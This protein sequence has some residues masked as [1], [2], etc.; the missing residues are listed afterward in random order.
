[1]LSLKVVML[2]VF[3][4]ALLLPLM[5]FQAVRGM[6]GV[7]ATVSVAIP[8]DPTVIAGAAVAAVAATTNAVAAAAGGGDMERSGSLL[9]L[10]C[11]PRPPRGTEPGEDDVDDETA[12]P[13]CQPPSDDDRL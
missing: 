7:G 6:A 12:E 8:A 10:E 9:V 3:A 2:A 13:V 11:L 5:D 1:M 4:L